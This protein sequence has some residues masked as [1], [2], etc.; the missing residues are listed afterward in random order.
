MDSLDFDDDELQEIF[1]H[2][3]ILV[4]RAG[5]ADWDKSTMDWLLERDFEEATEETA[6]RRRVILEEIIDYSNYFSEYLRVRSTSSIAAHKEMLSEVLHTNDGEKSVDSAILE[7][8]EGR[9]QSLL[10]SDAN[11]DKMLD[12]L[13][14]FTALLEGQPNNFFDREG[15]E[16]SFDYDG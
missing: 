5:Y 9:E 7:T 8:D 10:Q 3:R 12:V 13:N 15:P 1:S 11:V 6:V 16:E 14:S 2:L 4:I